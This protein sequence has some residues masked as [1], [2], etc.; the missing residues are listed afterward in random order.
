MKIQNPKTVCGDFTY[1]ASRKMNFEIG[2]CLYFGSLYL[3]IAIIFFLLNPFGFFEKLTTD[4]AL[5]VLSL[6]FPILLALIYVTTA[7]L[8]L[9]SHLEPKPNKFGLYR[10]TEQVDVTD[11]VLEICRYSMAAA[12][13]CLILA[14]TSQIDLFKPAFYIFLFLPIAGM[15]SKFLLNLQIWQNK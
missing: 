3:S 14:I 4:I 9:V 7:K 10:L 13:L 8:K 11:K 1:P 15:Y 5:I 12:F 2:R 6:F